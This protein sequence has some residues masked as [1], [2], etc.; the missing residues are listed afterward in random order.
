M[1]ETTRRSITG[2]SRRWASSRRVKRGLLERHV[3]QALARELGHRL[4]A[5]ARVRLHADHGAHVGRHD[6]DVAARAA[7]RDGGAGPPSELLNY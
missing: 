4:L 3:R 2:T 1:T 5:H 6:R 7:A